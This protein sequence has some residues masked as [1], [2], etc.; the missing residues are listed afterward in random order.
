MDLAGANSISHQLG[1]AKTTKI[2]DDGRAD[3]RNRRAG[4][5]RFCNLGESPAFEDESLFVRTPDVPSDLVLD[6]TT[7]PMAIRK[8]L[9]RSTGRTRRSRRSA[10]GCTANAT[11]GHD[12]QAKTVS[13]HGKG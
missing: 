5:G 1:S 7:K 4:G 10:N 11:Q 8:G 13:K 2:Y 12:T 9:N 6:S 3:Q